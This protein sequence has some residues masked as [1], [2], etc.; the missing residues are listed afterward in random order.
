MIE[1][2]SFGV[3]NLDELAD[4]ASCREYHFFTKKGTTFLGCATVCR[5][6]NNFFSNLDLF[7]RVITD[8]VSDSDQNKF[9][10]ASKKI[11]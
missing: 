7:F 4:V 2:L 10:K 1:S 11:F 9:F 8:S 6:R 3:V 5:Q